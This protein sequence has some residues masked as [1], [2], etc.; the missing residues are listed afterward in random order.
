MNSMSTYSDPDY[1]TPAPQEALDVHAALANW[2][3]YRITDS[4]EGA[5]RRGTELTAEAIDQT[6]TREQIRDVHTPGW[7]D[8]SPLA[9]IEIPIPPATQ[10]VYAPQRPG[11]AH[12]RFAR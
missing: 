10:D 7:M 2:P 5:I 4:Q 9:T 12:P 11:A 8:W 6:G 1:R 3:S